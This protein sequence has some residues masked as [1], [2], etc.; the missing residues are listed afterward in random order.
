[1]EDT[2]IYPAAQLRNLGLGPQLLL[3]LPRCSHPEDLLLFPTF[4][5]GSQFRPQSSH[6]D[7]TA[8]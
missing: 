6:L 5:T 4:S 2:T 8:S 1:M 3:L 7:V